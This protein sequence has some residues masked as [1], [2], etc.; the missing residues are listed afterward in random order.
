M[1]GA[2]NKEINF[3]C[4]H[5]QHWWY[6]GE[7]SWL[8]NSVHIAL[9]IEIHFALCNNYKFHT[10]VCILSYFSEN[11]EKRKKKNP[12][13]LILV[14]LGL[15][16]RFWQILDVSFNILLKYNRHDKKYTHCKLVCL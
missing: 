13:I 11:A 6:S 1:T 3:K 12:A 8:P 5:L 14:F 4:P 7:E 16:F 15:Q 10:F 9:L 2:N